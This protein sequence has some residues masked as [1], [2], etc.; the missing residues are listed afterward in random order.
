MTASPVR[1]CL[2]FSNT[3]GYLG[4]L[5][6]GFDELGVFAEFICLKT[7]RARY[8]RQRP[9][10]FFLRTC[11]D[12]DE[13]RASIPRVLQVLTKP[14]QWCI[15][16]FLLVYLLF[17][18]DIFILN[19]LPQPFLFYGELPILKFFKKK[20]IV[21]FHGSDARPPYMNGVF[22]PDGL[23]T[24]DV[25][26]SIYKATQFIKK[27][28]NYTEKYADV[29]VNHTACG[30]FFTKPFV[31]WQAIGM[32][33]DTT[34]S[35]DKTDANPT[36]IRIIHAPSRPQAKGTPVVREIIARLSKEYDITYIELINKTNA[37]VLETLASCD[38]VVDEVYSDL[39]MGALGMEAAYFGKPVLSSGYFS[40]QHTVFNPPSF[41][42]KPEEL[43]QTLRT[44][45]TDKA[46]RQDVG[47]KA[48]DFVCREWTPKQV[49]SRYMAIFQNQ[50][51]SAWFFNPKDLLYFHGVAMRAPMVYQLLKLFI[52]KYGW[53]T[54]ALSHNP[55]LLEHIKTF[56]KGEPHEL[57]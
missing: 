56:I 2:G 38:L 33:F 57:G 39:P 13:M 25:L 18:F 12:F 28:V 4:T 53:D 54:L 24:D 15:H 43:E 23:V 21:I 16:G 36:G 9:G 46:L 47:K 3:T 34:L 5:K 1:V 8:V 27:Q 37:E 55:L 50:I 17:K 32:P 22:L 10:S 7:D 44:L 35:S 51:P 30:Q 49:A 42:C 45:I 11:E 52:A 48:Q 29:C 20:V 6:K 40:D 19:H 14:L 31:Q 26:P 41:F